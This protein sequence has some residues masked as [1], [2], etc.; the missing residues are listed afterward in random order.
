MEG[1]GG[2]GDLQ[3]VVGE[4]D[5]ECVQCLLD[6][7]IDVCEGSEDGMMLLMLVVQNGYVEV[8]C[9]FF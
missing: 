8:V 1:G 7:G 6:V 9:V 4:G 2:V 5:L 3:K